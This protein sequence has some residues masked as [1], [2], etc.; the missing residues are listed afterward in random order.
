MR[1]QQ[2]RRILDELA[3]REIPADVDLW[4]TI[5][6][7][8]LNASRARRPARPIS[9]LRWALLFPVLA[10]VMAVTAYAMTA[11]WGRMP[12]W[13]PVEENELGT[14]L[15][16]SQ[17]M[18]G[19]TVTLERAYADAN[20]IL[21]GFTVTGPEDRPVMASG[22]LRGPDGN[23][24]QEL[25]GTGLSGQSELLGLSLPPGV[26]AHVLA[27]DASG[28]PATVAELPLRFEV[29]LVWWEEPAAGGVQ[30]QE[31]EGTPPAEETDVKRVV[32]Q[33]MRLNS[34]AGPFVFDFNVPFYQGQR[35]ELAQ[36]IAQRGIAMTLQ[37]VTFTPTGARAILCYEVPGKETA[38]WAWLP[39]ATLQGAG[40]QLEGITSSRMGD[41]CYRVSFMADREPLPVRRPAEWV[42]T[43][44]EIVGLMT[45][46]SPSTSEGEEGQTVGPI[47][48]PRLAGPWVFHFRVP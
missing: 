6:A 23:V 39:V 25:V 11:L 12:F 43:V 24:V 13:Q 20:Q 5:R 47:E 33:P 10:L 40:R 2:L 16:L 45:P 22:T 8:L 19:Y 27:F 21:I 48:P 4:P 46:P 9:R 29:N 42:L 18:N 14:A 17:T 38:S 28:L 35:V 41:N 32:V 44:K 36:T 26:Q 15:H 1:D 7:R 3:S 34:V 31:P 30:P 37:R